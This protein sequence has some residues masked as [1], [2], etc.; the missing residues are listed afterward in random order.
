MYKYFCHTRGGTVEHTGRTRQ[1]SCNVAAS[2]SRSARLLY[3][4]GF[5]LACRKKART[6]VLLL[7]RISGVAKTSF[8]ARASKFLFRVMTLKGDIKICMTRG[9]PSWLS[10][11]KTPPR[12]RFTM[13]MSLV[14]GCTTTPICDRKISGMLEALCNK[15]STKTLTL[16]SSSIT[17]LIRASFLSL[18]DVRL[19]RP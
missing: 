13:Q 16:K 12:I 4:E 6:A 9:P 8:T 10:R 2:R 17:G 14:S 3:L 15:S 18:K 11:S 19:E 5:N 7:Q 1:P